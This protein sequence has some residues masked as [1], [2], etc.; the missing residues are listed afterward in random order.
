MCCS[1]VISFSDFK[2]FILPF[3]NPPGSVLSLEDL[4]AATHNGMRGGL[5]QHLHGNEEPEPDMDINHWG[6]M[7]RGR[8]RGVTGMRRAVGIAGLGV[9]DG[10]VLGAVKNTGGKR[11][12]VER[13]PVTG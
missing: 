3:P 6:G 12:V 13:P 10:K 7:Q 2:T 5:L 11:Q 9:G 8:D 4:H 1:K